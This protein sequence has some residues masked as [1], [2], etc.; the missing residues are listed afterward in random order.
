MKPDDAGQRPPM[1]GVADPPLPFEGGRQ[2]VSDEEIARIR[3]RALVLY[4][5]APAVSAAALLAGFA[6]R[7]PAVAA[8]G[9]IGL[10]ATAIVAG[11]LAMAERR[12]LFLARGLA[13]SRTRHVVYEGLAAVPFGLSWVVAGATVVAAA[14]A[15][16]AGTGPFALRAR[17]A[18]RPA[19][20]LVP[21]GAYLLAT[22]LGL[23]IGFSRRTGTPGQRVAGWLVELPTRLGG[24]LLAV[25][26]ALA[27]AA[28][29]VEWLR[30]AV[31]DAW[32]AEVAAGRL[33]F[34]P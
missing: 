12:L 11:L 22:G 32:L 34:G 10:G 21:A 1:Q 5:A 31:F 25:L 14:V 3:R 33:P 4:I 26:G 27:L 17:I 13:M 9:A 28:G 23:V 6:Q 30:P 16:L 7:R 19:L 8:A 20:A 15:T 24:A 29:V 2:A 18:E